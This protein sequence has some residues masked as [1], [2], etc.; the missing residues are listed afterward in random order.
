MTNPPVELMG[1]SQ[2]LQGAGKATAG[3]RAKLS[4]YL[5]NMAAAETPEALEAILQSGFAHSFSGPTWSR[6]CKCRVETGEKICESH[7]LGKYVPR[8]STGRRLTLLG[9]TYKVPNGGNSTGVRYAWHDAGQWAKNILREHGFS[10]RAAH[11]IWERCLDYP[12]RAIGLIEKALAGEI[13]DPELNV[14]IL[15][16]RYDHGSPINYTEE[17][18]NAGDRRATLPCKCGG[19]L[20]DW[21][22]G[23]SE[24]FEFIN[25]RCNKCPDVFSEYMTSAQFYALRQSKRNEE[26]PAA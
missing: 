2:V 14:L 21:G 16:E 19:T 3:K 18:N 1:A 15:H 6:I 23:H 25:W 22:G 20:F 11:R 26:R 5:S 24:G 17:Q 7:P 12:H 8:Y 9:E 4:E 13:P 10:R